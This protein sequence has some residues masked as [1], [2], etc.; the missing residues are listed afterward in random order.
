MEDSAF[1]QGGLGLLPH[2]NLCFTP[3]N[4]THT[5]AD[6]FGLLIYKFAR[7]LSV[8]DDVPPASFESSSCF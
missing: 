2:V 6:H 8:G 4:H 7:P 5:L 3:E 1:R